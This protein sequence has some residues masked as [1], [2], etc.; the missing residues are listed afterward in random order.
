MLTLQV[1]MEEKGV[2]NYNLPVNPPL[3]VICTY[4][5]MKPME[6]LFLYDLTETLMY[7]RTLWCETDNNISDVRKREARIRMSLEDKPWF[8]FHGDLEII[9]LHAREDIHNNMNHLVMQM[10][11]PYERLSPHP[12]AIDMDSQNSISYELEQLCATIEP[13][14]FV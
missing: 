8:Q 9:C 4:L 11:V 1:I 12:E 10:E 6:Q 7:P 14:P 13:R 2:L 5:N 3:H